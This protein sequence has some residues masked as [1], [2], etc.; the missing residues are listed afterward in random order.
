[1]VDKTECR[2]E[3]AEYAHKAWA[4]WMQYLFSVSYPEL[5]Q[6][7]KE[8]GDVVIPRWAVERWTR[9]MNTEYDDLSEKEKDS[10][11]KEADEMLAIIQN[12]EA[13]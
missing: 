3:L 11:R 8:T 5:G 7:D 9:Q 10:D 4:G 6:F 12:K 1:M 13:T 2:E